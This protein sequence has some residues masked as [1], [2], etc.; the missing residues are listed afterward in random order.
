MKKLCLG[1]L[2]FVS[3]G[4]HVPL[5][6]SEE[7]GVEQIA[8]G[9]TSCGPLFLDAAVEASR[10]EQLSSSG[11]SL[12]PNAPSADQQNAL[13]LVAVLPAGNIS[14]ADRGASS[15]KPEKSCGPLFLESALPISSGAAQ[16]SA[17]APKDTAAHPGSI[18]DIRPELPNRR[19][20]QGNSSKGT[21]EALR[22]DA[23]PA[24]TTAGVR[25]RSVRVHSD[26]QERVV[27]PTR[28]ADLSAWWP[29]VEADQL[30]IHFV[31]GANFVTAIAMLTDGRFLDGE[32]ANRHIEVED[33]RGRKLRAAWV[34]AVNEQVLLMRVA[35]GL[36][37][38]RISPDFVDAQ[39]KTLGRQATG[40]VFVD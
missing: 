9:R 22:A 18:A 14:P 36:Y 26:V 23:E 12:G 10:L 3:V 19:V 16:A 30:N 28:P 1:L 27:I 4:A 34:P 24:E 31:G 35:P 2:M 25:R 37:T 11:R 6:Q 38:L 32:S 39:G 29:E 20:N 13:A 15:T 21:R 33:Q 40:R 7:T 8:N 17:S 5:A